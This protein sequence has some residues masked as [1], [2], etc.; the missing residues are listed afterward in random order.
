MHEV[1]ALAT[2]LRE[3]GIQ[4]DNAELLED[5]DISVLTAEATFI[6]DAIYN[7]TNTTFFN[8]NELMK[9]KDMKYKIGDVVDTTKASNQTTITTGIAFEESLDDFTT[10]GADD[11][12][13][14]VLQDVALSLGNV[15]QA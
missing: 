5:D 13:D 8:S 7:I 6:Y 15:A 10:V 12:A 4:A 2:E 14:L 3:L 9:E 1:G 11:T